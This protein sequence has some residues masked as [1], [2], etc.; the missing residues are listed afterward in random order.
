MLPFK[1]L[2]IARSSAV[3]FL[4]EEGEGGERVCGSADLAKNLLRFADFNN[5]FSGSA[6]PINL[7]DS[8][9]G[10]NRVRITDS[11]RNLAGNQTILTFLTDHNLSRFLYCINHKFEY[12]IVLLI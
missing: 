1:S 2:E 3:I 6:D 7:M 10:K 11:K 12:P 4:G 8:G 9:F 5:N